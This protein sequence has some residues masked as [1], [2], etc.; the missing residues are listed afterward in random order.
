MSTL[1]ADTIQN[2]TGGAATL[3][4]Q[5]AAKAFAK[6]SFYDTTVEKSLNVASATDNGTGDTTYTLTNAMDSADYAVAFGRGRSASNYTNSKTGF[7]LIRDNVTLPTSSAVRLGGFDSEAVNFDFDIMCCTWM[8][9]L[10]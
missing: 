2:T 10:A 4:K 5:S 3:T 8:G 7:M 6:G 9:D 1:R